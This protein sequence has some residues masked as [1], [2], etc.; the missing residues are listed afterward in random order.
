MGLVWSNFFESGTI[1]R[2]SALACRASGISLLAA[3]ALLSKIEDQNA[4][5]AVIEIGASPLEPYNGKLAIELVQKHIRFSVLC[6]S[7]PY[8]VYG[9]MKAFQ[10]KPDLVSGVAS[11]TLAG[12]ALIEKLCGVRPV[13]SS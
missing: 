9:V 7:D 3:K 11:N 6:A 2:F 13:S 8:A 4:D 12:I 5:V 1:W 10:F